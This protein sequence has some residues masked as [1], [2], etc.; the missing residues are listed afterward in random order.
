MA[1]TPNDAIEERRREI[2]KKRN[3][4]KSKRRKRFLKRFL[5]FLCIVAVITLV[6]LSLTVFFPIQKITVDS[7]LGI[8]TNEQIIEAS[9]IKKGENLWMSGLNAEENIPTKLPFISKAEIDRKFPSSV[10]IKTELAK[11]SYCFYIEKDYYICDSE[12][13]VLEIKK[14]QNENTV[15][16]LGTGASKTKAGNKLLFSDIKKS[17]LMEKLI[18][19]LKEK[20]INVNTIDITE[21]MDMKVRVEGR[22]NVSLGSS[23]H[24]EAKVSHLAGMLQKVENDVK[25]SIDLSDYTPENGRGILTRE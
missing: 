25:G 23:A 10:I 20:N 19:L 17:E 24:F 13:K 2:Q 22:F 16:I 9:G 21:S 15:L 5:I 1:V 6:I 14:E 11:A 7:S 12:Y 18:S 3:A 8:Y 4:A